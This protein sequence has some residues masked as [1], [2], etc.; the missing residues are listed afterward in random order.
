MKSIKRYLII[1]AV[2]IIVFT[3]MGCS[4][5][6][7]QVTDK[8]KT[9]EVI[10]KESNS[11]YWD[12]VKVGAE[13]AGKEF[14]VDII[15][16]APKKEEEI[17]TQIEII[18]DAINKKVNAIVLAACDYKRLVNVTE[19]AIDEG[20]PVVVI[21]SAIDSSKISS[22]IAT[23]NFEAGKMQGNQLVK[24]IGENCNVALMNFV[25]GAAPADQRQAGFLEVIK[26]YPDIKVLS[27]EYCF[28]DSMLSSQLTRK[29]LNKF[30]NLDAIV[31]FNA[32]ATEGA[33]N[34]VKDM[35][36]ENKIKIIGFD[37]MPEEVDLIEDG[38]IQTTVVQ[39]PYSM[40]Y[41][42]VKYALDVLNK[43]SVPKYVDTHSTQIDKS[44]MYTPENQKL[45]FPFVK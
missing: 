10:V 12:S 13:D 14:G 21:D 16:S 25:K 4:K 41:L 38:V 15:Y 22:F 43:K 11:S 31:A 2:C 44:N 39:N 30:T 33:A 26:I 29:L 36:L 24:I 34:T 3:W 17:D 27:N 32:P 28:S 6:E 37:C 7:I 23:D 18:N 9:I 42:G 20:I 19:K 40:G 5:S 8:K 35:K 1:L 45:I